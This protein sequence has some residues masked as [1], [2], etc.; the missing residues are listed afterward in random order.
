VNLPICQTCGVQYDDAHFDPD[1]CKICEDERQYVG[2]DGQRWT[3]L[4]GLTKAGHRGV[5]REEGPE[6]VGVGTEPPLAI[7]Q[8]ALLVPGDGGNVLWDC[9]PCLDDT[10]AAVRARGGIAA[11]ALSHPHFYGSMVEWSK[12]FG[13]V[14]IYIH[15]ADREWVCRDG[16]IVFWEGE[17]R[18]ILPGR[19]LINCG[20]HFAG[21]TVLHW[22]DGAGGRGALCSGDIFTVV[23][24]RRWVSFMYSYPNLIPEAPETIER[25]LRLVE[26]L[27]F[28]V[29]Y[30]G[31]WG[32][33]VGAEGKAALR[34]SAARY[35]EHIGY[36]RE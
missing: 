35:L 34:R 31:W 22:A 8:R 24:D 2:W 16:N 25:A 11:I 20:V 15:A 28:E 3:T 36:P 27:S 29:I 5:V 17:R 30:G 13:D 6:L 26:P 4:E 1:H 14:P 23:L 33:V 10:V 21:G 9:V 18:E 7:G 32:R 12:A 19:T